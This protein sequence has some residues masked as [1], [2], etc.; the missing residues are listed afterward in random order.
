[1]ASIRRKEQATALASIL[2]NPLR[3]AI[4]DRLRG[5]PSIVGVLVDDVGESQAT[6]S[7]QLGILRD[8]GLLQCRPEGR[9]R[10]YALADPPLVDAVMEALFALAAQAAATGAKC[11][12]RRAA[13]AAG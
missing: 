6:V 2:S 8:A 13:R 4:V 5:G 11:R 9:C 10:E 1:M 12:S 7:K 3:L